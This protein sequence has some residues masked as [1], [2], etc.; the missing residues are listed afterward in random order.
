MTM[1][2]ALVMITPAKSDSMEKEKEFIISA[3]DFKEVKKEID[4]DDIKNIV[5]NGKQYADIIIANITE[6]EARELAI[7]NEV[8]SIESNINLFAHSDNS[9]TE[10][11]NEDFWNIQMINADQVD[12]DMNVEDKIKIG[13]IDTGINVNSEYNV[14]NEID[15][16]DESTFLFQDFSG[17][18]TSVAGVIASS[19]AYGINNNVELYSIKALNQNN[20]AKLSDVIAGIYW[21]I[22]NDLDILNMSFGTSKY[23]E[24]F[25]IAINDAYNAGLLIVASAGNDETLKYPAAFENV[26]AVGSV[27]NE[28]NVVSKNLSQY[29]K[30]LCAPGTNIVSTGDFDSNSMNTGTSMAAPHVTAVASLLWQIDKT[31]SNTFIKDLLFASANNSIL[32]AKIVDAKYAIDNYENFATNYS[33]NA[34]NVLENN[35]YQIETFTDDIVEALWGSA[36][37]ESTVNISDFPIVEDFMKYMSSVPDNDAYTLGDSIEFE[38]YFGLTEGSYIVLS[39]GSRFYTNDIYAFPYKAVLHGRGNYVSSLRFLYS[40]AK[41]LVDPNNNY[42]GSRIDKL[43]AAI[44]DSL[45][46]NDIAN[47]TFYGDSNSYCDSYCDWRVIPTETNKQYIHGVGIKNV[48]A[49]F[50]G[51]S[52]LFSSLEQR[53]LLEK[54]IYLICNYY[55][56]DQ[57]LAYN[58]LLNSGKFSN[59][60]AEN[61]FEVR[62]A[63]KILGLATHLCGDIY[64]HKTVVPIGSSTTFVSNTIQGARDETAIYRGTATD[65]YGYGRWTGPSGIKT[66]ISGNSAITTQSINEWQID[67]KNSTIKYADSALFYSDRLEIGAKD[68]VDNMYDNFFNGNS[69][70][71]M[72]FYTNWFLHENYTL[73]LA[74]LKYYAYITGIAPER[75]DR[76]QKLHNLDS[77]VCLADVFLSSSFAPPTNTVDGYWG[78]GYVTSYV[79]PE[80]GS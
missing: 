32:G 56:P 14:C 51:G 75:G 29:N 47:N 11:S 17:H 68:L 10:T 71:H 7:N 23:S 57:T 3:T 64:A 36:N 33:N 70:G 55:I 60:T 53:L 28:G 15:Y 49:K 22:E 61:G 35:N 66:L 19:N 74:N 5:K 31:K 65:F 27:D 78:K 52:S 20:V 67:V 72:G 4:N 18:G 38:N 77:A 58:E 8:Q 2:T 44:E 45:G 41:N 24:A 59:V 30:I 13:I 1:L 50:G 40:V 73:R 79:D 62:A 39:N 48:V 63:L 21:A 26:I 54:A 25:E 76:K 80:D 6:T 16:T 43:S 12:I 42:T 9:Q 46:P 69:L 37:H 34:S